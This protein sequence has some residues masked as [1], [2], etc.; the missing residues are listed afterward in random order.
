MAG[1]CLCL[2]PMLGLAASSPALVLLRGEAAGPQVSIVRVS[3]LDNL[4][5][6]SPAGAT[7]EVRDGAGRTYLQTRSDGRVSFQAGGALGVTFGAFF[8]DGHD[9]RLA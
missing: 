5:L 7:V 9:A 4:T 3:P 1:L 8:E 2:G 6:L